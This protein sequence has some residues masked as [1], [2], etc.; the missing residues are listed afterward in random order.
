MPRNKH[1][2][3][4]ISYALLSTAFFIGFF[5][6]FAPA[7]F[8]EPMGHS[9]DLSAAAL[10]GLAAIHFWV[11]TLMQ[12]PAG[13][14]IDRF[15]IHLPAVIGTLLTG[16]GAITLGMTESYTLALMGP[17]LV[18]LGMS[19]VFV[20]VMKN[21]AL[22][23][24]ERQFGMVTGATL[25]IGT[26]GSIA[27]ES[28]ARLL[29]ELTD[30]RAIFLTLGLITIATAFLIL[31]FWRPPPGSSKQQS[32]A[33]TQPLDSQP[34]GLWLSVMKNR[35]LWLILMAISGTN[36]TF[37]AFAGLWGTQLLSDGYGL[38]SASASLILTLALI[39]YGLGSPIFGQFSDLLKT[40]KR[41]IW[42]SSLV[43][44]A[45]WLWLLLVP[46]S[47]FTESLIC[48]LALG[49]SSGAQVA[50]AF[51][52]VK[53]TV[54][55]DTLGSAIAFVNMGVFL[56]TAIIQTAYGWMISLDGTTAISGTLY[57]SSLW[58]PAC[59]SAIGFFAAMWIKETYPSVH[60]TPPA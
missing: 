41:F 13:V 22:W 50:V 14:V 48:F 30:W 56:V 44:M 8:S 55:A 38:P 35:Q 26:L 51:A 16:I 9:L 25:L 54:H 20:A 28:P 29:L 23:F 58:L 33:R 34:R 57:R 43:N 7:T 59:L 11:Y 6:R 3:R 46:T 37:Y 4:F 42:I 53:E 2:A 32:P 39:P 12:V 15:G 31:F 40:R 19:L 52:A 5:N 21:N 60:Q 1:S 27:S 17:F 47:G 24:D 45:A 49:L 18:G 36:G 10:G